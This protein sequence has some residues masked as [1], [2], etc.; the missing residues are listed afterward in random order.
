MADQT[1]LFRQLEI[2][3]VFAPRCLVRRVTVRTT[4]RGDRVAGR[5]EI[6]CGPAS[7]FRRGDF[8]GDARRQYLRRRGVGG[9]GPIGIVMANQAQ[10]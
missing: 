9:D 6:G 5:F 7:G 10:R 4:G 3:Q 2:H 1:V 8:C